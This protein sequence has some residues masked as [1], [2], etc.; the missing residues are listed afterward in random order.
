MS[1][2]SLTDNDKTHLKE[3]YDNKNIHMTIDGLTVIRIMSLGSAYG[4]VAVNTNGATSNRVLVYKVNYDSSGNIT[5]DTFS[6]FLSYYLVGNSYQPSG[7]IITSDNWSQYIS[8]SGNSWNNTTDVSTS[9]LYNAK[10]LMI[11]FTGPSGEVSFFYGYFPNGLGSEQGS[12]YLIPYSTT[13]TGGYFQYN[14]SSIELYNTQ[15]SISMIY[16]KT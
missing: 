9:D 6:L 4:Y 10:D 3:I 7:D 15:Y 2:Q 8:V 11:K 14:G 1:N 12:Y 13:F 16:Y 5:S